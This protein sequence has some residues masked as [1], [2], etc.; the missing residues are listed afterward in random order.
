MTLE[1]FDWSDRAQVISHARQ[2]S[3]RGAGAITV[4]RIPDQI[5]YHIV[6]THNQERWGVSDDVI[7]L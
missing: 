5:D 7:H 1:T 6:P 3:L 4:Y 2:I